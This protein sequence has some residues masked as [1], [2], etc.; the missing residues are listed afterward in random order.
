LV[1]SMNSL[2]SWSVSK[3][4]LRTYTVWYRMFMSIYATLT[5]HRCT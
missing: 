2:P 4:P 5:A 1:E 3:R